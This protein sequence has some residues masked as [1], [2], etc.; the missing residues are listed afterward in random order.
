MKTFRVCQ[1]SRRVATRLR[2]QVALVVSLLAL[3]C[4]EK[5]G[6]S[7]VSSGGSSE[8]SSEDLAVAYL[9]AAFDGDEAKAASYVHERTDARY[10]GSDPANSRR[11]A[12]IA[13]QRGG[14]S[15]IEVVQTAS[16]RPPTEEVLCRVHFKDG[17]IIEVSVSTDV[18]ERTDGSSNENSAKTRRVYR[19]YMPAV[20]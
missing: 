15:Q 6:S 14:T 12:E 19:L 20:R 11:L 9:R 7:V 1:S 16:E 3:G 8:V 18:V 5:S 13:R 4:A 10:G 2:T 17:S